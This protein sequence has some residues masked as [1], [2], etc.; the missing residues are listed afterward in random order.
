[1]TWE[2]IE[3][4]IQ[5]HDE[6]I[7]HL[8]ESQSELR[9]IVRLAS[10]QALTAVQKLAAQVTKFGERAMELSERLDIFINVV[11]KHIT[12]DRRHLPPRQAE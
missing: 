12:D 10:E 5:K 7:G 1:M 2:E 9:E 8:I 3:R 4:S 11:E 6:Q